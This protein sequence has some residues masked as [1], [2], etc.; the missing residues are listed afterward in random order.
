M[1]PTRGI[2][3]D[4]DGTLLDSNHAHAEAWRL[5]LKE[6]GIEVDYRTVRE[7]IGMGGD[8]LLPGVA[9]IESGSEQGRAASEA[10]D[11]IFRQ[12]FFEGLRPFPG[13]K[14]LVAELAARGFRIA[15]ASSAGK[16]ELA[17]FLRILDIEQYLVGSTSGDDAESSKP[18]PDVILAALRRL[19]CQADEAVMIGDTPYDLTA[20]ERAGVRSV[21]VRSGGWKDRDLRGAAEIY[22]GPADLLA[23]LDRSP[24]FSGGGGAPHGYRGGQHE[25]ARN[26][27]QL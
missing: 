12:R 16:E 8:Q 4:I 19:G 25:H 6:L 22:D 9:G 15:V 21:A 2:I 27:G 26:P 13:A 24:I 5:G 3:F 17:K 7:A 20:A 14:D 10:K 1:R 11:R 18:E 23:R